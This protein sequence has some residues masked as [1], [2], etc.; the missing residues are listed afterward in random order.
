MVLATVPKNS[1]RA[2]L[3]GSSRS[4]PTPRII[5]LVSH[6]MAG[7]DAHIAKL[8]YIHPPSDDVAQRRY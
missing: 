5:G 2:G 7:F 6:P 3:C 4:I 1:E 8:I